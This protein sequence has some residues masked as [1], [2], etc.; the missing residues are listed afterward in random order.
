MGSSARLGAAA[1]AI[2]LIASLGVAF[3]A[4]ASG[5][6]SPAAT[7]AISC[8][9]SPVQA[10]RAVDGVTL[11]P[12]QISDALVIYDASV[13][14]G[15]P[16][17]AAVI[18]EATSMQESR[19]INLPDG[20]SDSLG[21]FQQ[22]PSQGWGTPA[23]I[24]QPVYASTRFYEALASVPGWQSL[25]LT[26]AAQAVQGS[27][28]PGAYAKWEPLA[29]SLVATFSG[30]TDNCLTDNGTGV[31]QSGIT[32]LPAGFALP[33]GTPQAV[34]AAI[35]YAADQLGKP[36]IFSGGPRGQ[37]TLNSRVCPAQKANSGNSSGAT[38]VVQATLDPEQR[39]V[40]AA[41]IL[42]ATA[43]L[44]KPY[45]WG[46]TGPG[47]YDCS[48]LV[49]M[50]YRAAG[51]SLP[52]TTFQQVYAGTAVYSFSD[53]MPGDLLFTPGSDGTAEDPGHVGMYVGQGLVIQAPQTGEDI[54]IT[55]FK[56]YWQ[57]NVV[58]VRRVV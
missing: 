36:Y 28:T 12:A 51:V 8:G 14:M 37:I 13:T 4:G 43:Q 11:D 47:G 50:A 49:M 38:G 20:T 26:V 6:T 34:V 30:N 29:G 58:A 23:Q 57:Q 33:S 9:T 21:L 25:P 2:P 41:A 46:G 44:G 39:C 54:E 56:G 18:A 5:A 48:G 15:L 27:A 3:A 17:R 16:Q 24:M 40:A 31:P 22:R 10:G 19:L 1:L 42:Y 32:H 53:L 52:R 35:A 45:V 55:P 7:P